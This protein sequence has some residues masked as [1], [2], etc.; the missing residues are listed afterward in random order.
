MSVISTYF[1]QYNCDFVIKIWHCDILKRNGIHIWFRHPNSCYRKL[2]N[3]KM[4]VQYLI[5]TGGNKKGKSLWWYTWEWTN[6]LIWGI[7]KKHDNITSYCSFLLTNLFFY[8]E[9]CQQNN[10]LNLNMN[11]IILQRNKVRSMP[12]LYMYTYILLILLLN[13]NV[14]HSDTFLLCDNFKEILSSTH[15]LMLW[16]K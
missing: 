9:T 4:S 12:D 15:V 1:I 10:T 7:L 5:H 3:I 13:P 6:M 14:K 11:Y 16:S 2:H 8:Y